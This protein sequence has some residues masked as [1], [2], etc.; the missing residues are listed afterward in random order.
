MEYEFDDLLLDW[1]LKDL[2]IICGESHEEIN[3]LVTALTL[4]VPFGIC[5]LLEQ[6][7]RKSKASQLQAIRTKRLH[8]LFELNFVYLKGSMS[9]IIVP[10]LDYA[11]E[12]GIK[13]TVKALYSFVAASPNM[14]YQA[15]FRFLLAVNM[16]CFIQRL[17]IR[18]N[19]KPIADGASALYSMLAFASN[20]SFYRDFYHLRFMNGKF[21]NCQEDVTPGVTDI[22]RFLGL[23]EVK[24]YPNII[25]YPKKLSSENIRFEGWS[26]SY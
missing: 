24:T 2:H 16:P 11:A 5:D 12:K 4:S 14:R 3:M 10:F 22:S 1:P 15:R 18:L 9:A 6:M 19:H 8:T 25:Q 26:L 21:V 7:G 20:H 13:P 17:G 23:E